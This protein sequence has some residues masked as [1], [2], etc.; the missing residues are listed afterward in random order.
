MREKNLVLMHQ[1]ISPAK[2]VN[3][4]LTAGIQAC[5]EEEKKESIGNYNTNVYY[6]DP[7][8]KEVWEQYRNISGGV[9]THLGLEIAYRKI[10]RAI[11][12]HCE[13]EVVDGTNTFAESD[14][15]R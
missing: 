12:A 1:P 2:A 13:G 7:R 10:M 4:V 6:P 8:I 5:E 14:H 15:K 11:K 9:L 3:D